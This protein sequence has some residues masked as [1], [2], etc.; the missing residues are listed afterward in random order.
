MKVLNHNNITEPVRT[1]TKVSIMCF[2]ASAKGTGLPVY[3]SIPDLF[4]MLPGHISSPCIGF[5]RLQLDL[6]STHALCLKVINVLPAALTQVT[7]RTLTPCCAGHLTFLSFIFLICKS[8]GQG[9]VPHQALNFLMQ[10]STYEVNERM[11]GGEIH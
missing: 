5:I 4:L 7:T 11:S 8:V 6:S 10:G 2:L 9:T 3:S 1:L